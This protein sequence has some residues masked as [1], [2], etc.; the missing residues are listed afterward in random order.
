MSTWLDALVQWGS[1]CLG[2]DDAWRDV[3]LENPV[4]ERDLESSS[5]EEGGGDER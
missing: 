3:V 4:E 2:D 5:E 1:D